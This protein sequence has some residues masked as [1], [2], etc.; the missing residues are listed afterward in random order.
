MQGL[1]GEQAVILARDVAVGRA[2][3]ER[4]APGVVRTTQGR[5]DFDLVVAAAAA[6]PG[7]GRPDWIRSSSGSP[8][9]PGR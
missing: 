9:G 4:P 6:I 2:I 5:I 8:G 3:I 1:T 7:R